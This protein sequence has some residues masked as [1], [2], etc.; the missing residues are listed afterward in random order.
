M[1]SGEDFDVLACGHT[2][3]QLVRELDGRFIVNCGSVAMPFV[4]PLLS[5]G[6]PRI[7]PWAEYAVLNLE[8]GHVE[9]DLLRVDYDVE[10]YFSRVR[11]SSLPDPEGW[12][13]AW[14]PR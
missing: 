2:H 8:R 1:V 9:V 5:P 14:L 12:I 7:L 10:E 11:A 6:V 4:E 3:V 13:A